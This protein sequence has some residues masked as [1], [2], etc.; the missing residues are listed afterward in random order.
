MTSS[1]PFVAKPIIRFEEPELV[2]ENP[3]HIITKNTGLF[4]GFKKDY[5]VVDFGPRAGVVAV[6]EG[7]VLLTAQYRFLIDAVTWELPG[8]RVDEGEDSIT[9]AH[10]ECIEETGYA[11]NVLHPLITYRPGL[12]N[13][14][15]LTQVFYCE[16]VQELK[17][18]VSDPQEVLQIAWIPIEEAIS[19]VMSHQLTD[20]MT[21]SGIL[22]YGCLKRD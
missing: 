20:A 12:D 22:A 13:V 9:A 19:L 4:H 16:D 5:F 10:R 8:G 2:H 21:V 1:L 3:F 7:E 11:C 14:E 15:N 18:F 6:K 17:P